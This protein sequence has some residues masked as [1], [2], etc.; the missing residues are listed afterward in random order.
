MSSNKP[1]GLY[2]EDRA[3]FR[4]ALLFTE[5]STGF[6]ARLIEKDYYCS[7]VLHDVSELFGQGL[8]FKGGTCLSK[9]YTEFFR[10]S[11]DLDF[12]VSVGVDATT[13]TRR[14]AALPH[15]VHVRSLP[16]RHGCFRETEPL[17]GHNLCSQYNGRFSYESVITGEADFIKVEIGL[18]EPLVMPAVD[19]SVSSDIYFSLS[20]TN[21]SPSPR[22]A[23]SL[24]DDN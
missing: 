15:R 5:S 14:K 2:H 18:R 11:E 12:A 17:T 8:I 20:A 24:P 6:S 4:E 3:Q 9:V 13:S 22:N 1:P 23:G 16:E 10:L 21:R 7:L 19:H